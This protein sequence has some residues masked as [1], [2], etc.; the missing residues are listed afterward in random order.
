MCL[1]VCGRQLW[2]LLLGIIS[3]VG[4]TSSLRIMLIKTF[5]YYI[6]CAYSINTQRQ[7]PEKKALK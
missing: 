3:Q 1:C 7:F 5:L 4:M 6:F 2:A